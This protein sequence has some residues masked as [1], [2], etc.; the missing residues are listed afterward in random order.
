MDF[1]NEINAAQIA[2]ESRGWQVFV[3]EDLKIAENPELVEKY[4]R[5]PK[6]ELRLLRLSLIQAHLDKIRASDAILVINLDKG[7][8]R[9][10]IGANTLI[11]MAFAYVLHKKI[12]VLN[13]IGPQKNQDEA[14]ALAEVILQGD[15]SNL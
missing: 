13:A 6:A 1:I 11:E 2:L 9:G 5:L 3:P 12:Y 7:E 8:A 10:Y 14:E 15:L 4:R